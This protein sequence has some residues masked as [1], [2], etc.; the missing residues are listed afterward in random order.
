[1]KRMLPLPRKDDQE[2]K[3]LF[4]DKKC[5]HNHQ[6]MTQGILNNLF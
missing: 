5:E 3:K 1:M 2:G 6:V 4:P